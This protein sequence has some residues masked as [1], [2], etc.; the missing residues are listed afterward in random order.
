MR[1]GGGGEARWKKALRV[2]LCAR[3]ALSTT[4][5]LLLV[6]SAHT[7]SVGS[8]ALIVLQ[9]FKLCPK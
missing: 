7:K 4:T 8:L 2:G 3:S 9:L 5:R 1:V 6:F